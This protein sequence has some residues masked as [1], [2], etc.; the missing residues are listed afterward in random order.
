M[1]HTTAGPNGLTF[2]YRPER[3]APVAAAIAG[4]HR[5]VVPVGQSAPCSI[6]MAMVDS[7][8]GSDVVRLT[9]PAEGFDRRP[10]CS[11]TRTSCARLATPYAVDGRGRADAVV[12]RGADARRRRRG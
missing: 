11:A 12:V 9:A 3:L 5:L 2:S 7:V 8:P 4:V 6:E 10:P 1:T